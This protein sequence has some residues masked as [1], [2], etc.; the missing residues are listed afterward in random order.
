MIHR[1]SLLAQFH[2]E[3]E[4]SVIASSEQQGNSWSRILG[5]DLEQPSCFGTSEG[6]LAC[7]QQ[8]FSWALLT[9]QCLEGED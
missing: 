2:R 6:N 1:K 3:Y 7:L 8:E 5:E 4:D 9:V